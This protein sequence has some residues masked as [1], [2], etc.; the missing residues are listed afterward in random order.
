MKTSNL[1]LPV[2]LLN[3]LHNAN[4]KIIYGIAGKLSYN[5]QLLIL[6]LLLKHYVNL[7]LIRIMSWL[8]NSR[9]LDDVI[10][11]VG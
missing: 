11:A 8:S 1:F 6:S 2:S 3:F 9:A 10:L 4:R 7:P 5:F